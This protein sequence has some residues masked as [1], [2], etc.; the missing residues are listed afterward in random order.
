M[1]IFMIVDDSPV[2]RRVGCRIISD[3]GFSVVEAGDGFEGLEK[4]RREMPDV[5]MVDW[6]LVGMT[7]L[8][9]IEDLNKIPAS[10]HT[11]VLYC[12]S[13]IMI[14]EMTKAKRAGASGFLMKP[15]NRE[16]VI[17]KLI[18]SGVMD[19]PPAAA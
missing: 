14:P 16:I 6:D 12:T 17:H 8:E 10:Q 18:E 7:G 3:L 19:Q 11:K 2:I 9:F 5:I 15:F 1:R 4:A 13:E